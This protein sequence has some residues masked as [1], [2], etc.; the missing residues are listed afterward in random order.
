M[1]LIEIQ[2]DHSAPAR[3]RPNER[4]TPTNTLQPSVDTLSQMASHLASIFG[5]EQDRSIS[6]S[7]LRL[8]LEGLLQLT[9]ARKMAGFLYRVNCSFYYKVCPSPASSFSPR[10]CLC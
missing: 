10:L 6:S 3:A 1:N 8:L 7:S 4:P 9:D 2:V 5:T